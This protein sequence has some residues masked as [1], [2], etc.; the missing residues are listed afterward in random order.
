MRRKRTV[1][2]LTITLL[3]CSASFAFASFTIWSLPEPVRLPRPFSYLEFNPSGK[4]EMR[5]IL[6]RP[7][8]TAASRYFSEYKTWRHIQASA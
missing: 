3:L 2:I 5:E 1:G 6:R 8:Q 4:P 7:I